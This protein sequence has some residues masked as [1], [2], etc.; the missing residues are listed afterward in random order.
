MSLV[1]TNFT[2]TAT[3]E[4]YKGQSSFE[5]QYEDPVEVECEIT[6][7]RTL[8]RNADG[9]VV[10]SSSRMKVSKDLDRIP[11]ESKVTFNGKEHKVINI[12][13]PRDRLIGS[14][15]HMELDLT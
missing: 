4:R 13:E 7:E 12:R 15:H 14:K 10:P 9:D 1:E 2:E 8:T 11:P 3:V 6:H 5:D